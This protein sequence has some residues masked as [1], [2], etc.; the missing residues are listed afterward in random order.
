MS[1]QTLIVQII[2]A[3]GQALRTNNLGEAAD[4]LN[5]KNTL[6]RPSTG[7]PNIDV[8]IKLETGSELRGQFND[9]TEALRLVDFATS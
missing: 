6:Q 1:A 7:T 8:Y 5:S 3:D 4:F 9:Y 2:A